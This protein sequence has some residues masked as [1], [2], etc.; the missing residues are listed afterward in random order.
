MITLWKRYVERAA[1]GGKFGTLG[2]KCWCPQ[3]RNQV[4]PPFHLPPP[5]PLGTHHQLQRFVEKSITLAVQV[6]V[7][8]ASFGHTDPGKAG[9]L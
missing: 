6:G 7:G 9:L 5:G 1:T 3:E 4:H 8:A 2:Q